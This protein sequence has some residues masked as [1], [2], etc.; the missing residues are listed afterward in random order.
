MS[1]FVPVCERRCSYSRAGKKKKK[2]KKKKGVRVFLDQQ[3]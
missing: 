3:R 1:G 2:K